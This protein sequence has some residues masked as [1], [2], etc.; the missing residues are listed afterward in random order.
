MTANRSARYILSLVTLLGSV[1]VSPISLDAQQHVVAGGEALYTCARLGFSADDNLRN[2]DVLVYNTTETDKRINDS[3][4]AAETKINDL[5]ARLE[6]E[7]AILRVQIK[8]LSDANDALTNRLNKIERPATSA[9]AP[10][11][12]AL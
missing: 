4:H 3:Q 5:N 8:T 2:C 6:T 9:D 1:V 10:K 12:G 7:I 11:R